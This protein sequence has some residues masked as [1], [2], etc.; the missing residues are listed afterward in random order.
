MQRLYTREQYMERIA[1]IKAARREI[2]I[3]SDIIV[4]FPGETEADI[5]QTLSLLEEVEYDAIFGFKYSPRPNT[6][7]LKLED[8]IPEEEKV[9][10]LTVLQ[11]KQREIQRRRYQRHHG[12]TL[13]V[14]VEGKNEARAQWSGRTSQNK[15]LNFKV[16][17]GIA[18]T[19]GS[20]VP[21]VTTGSF[22]NSLLGEMVI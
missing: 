12:Q 7:S 10:R 2:S 5:E 4:G 1:W 3:T 8:A 11:E 20:Y 22:P 18:P 21:V 16:P 13:E 9:R 19:V 6:P 15:I 14:M 17:E